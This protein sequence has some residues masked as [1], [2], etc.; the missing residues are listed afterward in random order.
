[1][2]ALAG[3]G[4]ADSPTLPARTALPAG[5]YRS[6]AF[7]PP[8][9]YR[10]PDGWLIAGDAADYFG[11]QPASSPMVGIYLFRS[12]LP[13]S[14]DPACP[15]T[16]EPGVGTTARELV[17][18]IEARPGL[19]VSDPETVTV[20]GLVGFRIDVA[21][22]AGWTPSCPFANGL[23]TVP[24]FVSAASEGFRWVVAGSERLRLDVL[25]VIGGGTVVIDIDSFEGSLMDAF[26][27]AAI[28]VVE[29]MRFG[30]P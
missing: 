4:G 15:T 10:L 26:L 11:L 24:L 28:P 7:S 25:D 22:V 6:S 29:T 3:C 14:Q 30:A 16:A 18:W 21:I 17:D 20:G 12:P 13:A 23:P 5:E 2:L 27:P 8:V 1:M 9:T 19:A